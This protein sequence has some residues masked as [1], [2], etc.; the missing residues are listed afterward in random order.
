MET[1]E[2][3]LILL[4]NGTQYQGSLLREIENPGSTQG[5]NKAEGSTKAYNKAVPSTQWKVGVRPL[6]H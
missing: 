6:L 2:K 4:L 1:S 5:K 3:R